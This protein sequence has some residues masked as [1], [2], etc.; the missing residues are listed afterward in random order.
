M[1][2]RICLKTPSIVLNFYEQMILY[3]ML[4]YILAKLL[5]G[6]F[7]IKYLL[8]KYNKQFFK[9]LSHSRFC[10]A[11]DFFNDYHNHILNYDQY[12]L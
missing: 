10:G 2:H 9:D 4:K 3:G 11:I 5:Y 12:F 8:R 6:E 1:A 7:N